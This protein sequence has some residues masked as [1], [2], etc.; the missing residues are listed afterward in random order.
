[1]KANKSR[2]IGLSA[3]TVALLG[4]AA[5]VFVAVGA[6]SFIAVYGQAM[7]ADTATRAEQATR[8]TA[9]A[10]ENYLS[11]M[12]EKLNR[13]AAEVTAD[14]LGSAR[15]LDVAVRLYTDVEAVMLWRADGS[16]A[17]CSAGD[18]QVKSAAAGSLSFDARAFDAGDACVISLPHVG[19]LY[20]ADY[21]WVVTLTRGLD[22]AAFGERIA[23]AV[24]FSFSG[25][26]QYIDNVGYGK[27]GYCY[28]IDRDGETVYHPQQQMLYA[29]IR[30]ENVEEVLHLADGAHVFDDAIRS[31]S[32]LSDGWRVV[33][34]SYTDELA[35]SRR[36]AVVRFVAA[37]L[38]CCVLIAAATVL[39]YARIVNRPVNRLVR[40]MQAFERAAETYAYAPMREP[41][42]ELQTLSDSFGHMVGMVQG[43]MAQIKAEE[44]SL[45]KTELKA[46]QAQI[47]PHFLYNTLDSIQ[48]MCEQGKNEDAVRMIS[49]LARLFRISI[50]RG[51]EL[52][53]IRDELRHAESYLVI[54]SYRYRDRFA[55][56]F[57]ADEALL[58]YL[59]NKITIQPL[60][61]NAIYHGIG[62]MPDDGVITV[63]VRRDPDAADADT[64]DI[65]I[66]VEDN[67]VGMTEA[68]C[69]AI[70]RKERSDSSGI[71]IKNVNDRL[72]IF[73]GERYGITIRSELDAGTCVTVRLPRVEK[74]DE[75]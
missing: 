42:A 14:S 43:L 20:E 60:I 37:V 67:G 9:A 59:C 62:N 64:A 28:V 48:W 53:P 33:G 73:F 16:L 32:T 29:G 21:P 4:V 46:L 17:V 30:S 24:D 36:Q 22:A 8:Q 2:H 40:A 19:N 1:M 11:N 27:H 52:I 50:S 44:L 63:R 10:L 39:L 74:E 70:L 23:I 18:R 72:K 61:E 71:G 55:Y 45:R 51:H 5:A 15:E 49:A 35:A 47:N 65:L 7:T 6:V 56:S 26:A 54:Q 34:V 3:L 69:A 66:E 57:E 31:V 38:L 12:E 58:G 75:A 13:I 41:V 25:I 68:Q